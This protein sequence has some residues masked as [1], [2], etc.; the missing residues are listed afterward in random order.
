METNQLDSERN[1]LVDTGDVGARETRVVNKLMIL[2]NYGCVL[3]YHCDEQ[4]E[5]Q[6]V[7]ASG[8]RLNEIKNWHCSINWYKVVFMAEQTGPELSNCHR[9]MTL[10]K[11]T[12]VSE[13]DP[14]IDKFLMNGFHSDNLT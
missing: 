6:E 12:M 7:M 5:M 2:Q 10:T 14:T 1:H 4:V 11:L 3:W 13:N 8:Q 9:A